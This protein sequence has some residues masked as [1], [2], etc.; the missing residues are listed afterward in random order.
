MKT[1]RVNE[2]KEV[3]SEYTDVILK[4]DYFWDDH[5]TLIPWND[6]VPDPTFWSH[7]NIKRIRYSFTERLLG[8][9]LDFVA[10][11][12]EV[13]GEIISGDCVNIFP[14]YEDNQLVIRCWIVVGWG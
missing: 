3:V 6:S 10:H 11:Q 14:E 9:E 4:V 2:K 7:A 1:T 13:N 12:L 8:R 5:G